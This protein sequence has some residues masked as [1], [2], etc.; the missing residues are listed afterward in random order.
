ME[1]KTNTAQGILKKPYV[2]PEFEV[3]ELDSQAPLL[4]ASGT[5]FG[6]GPDDGGELDD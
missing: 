2:Q 5:R 1:N 6:S 3:I 4:T